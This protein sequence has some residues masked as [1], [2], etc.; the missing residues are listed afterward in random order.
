MFPRVRVVRVLLTIV[1]ILISGPLFGQTVTRIVPPLN[2][3]RDFKYRS[4]FECQPCHPRQFR[5][6]RQ[7][8]K[9]GYRNFSPT[10][11]TL[12]MAGNTNQGVQ[13]LLEAGAIRTNLRPPATGSSL[14]NFV[15]GG[16]DQKA[17]DE[18][19]G[20]LCLG[21]HNGQT[22][23]LGENSADAAPPREVPPWDGRFVANHT[24]GAPEGSRYIDGV[25][26]RPLRDYH[27]VDANGNQ[28]LPDKFG[29][30][31]PAGAQTSLGGFGVSCDYCHNV[32][33]PDLARSFQGDGFGNVGLQLLYSDF[34]A[35]PFKNAFPPFGRFHMS[36]NLEERINYIRSPMLCNACHDVRL[37]FGN[38]VAQ[39]DTSHP[40]TVPHYRLE[41]LSTEWTIGPY[42]NAAQNPFNQSVR[43]QDCHM[44]LYPYAGDSSYSVT[45]PVTGEQIQ[46]TSPTPAIFPINF[47]AEGVR[48]IQNGDYGTDGNV[49]LPRRQVVTHYFTG[50]D[51]PLLYDSELKAFLGDDYP[52]TD[53][54]GKD[55]YGIPQSIRTRREDLAKAA[56]R[57]DLDRS[58]PNATL[59]QEFT[60][61]VR[62]VALTGHRLPAGFSQ[63]RG[64]WI[65][66]TV[67][68]TEKNTGK[69]FVLYQSGYLVD[70]PHPE[71]NETTRD[72]N[73][74]DEDQEHLEAIVNPFNH[75]NEVFH[76][77]PD[78][79][80]HARIFEG[81]KE[82]LVF[83][84]NELIR[85]YGPARLPV[86]K[87]FLPIHNYDELLDVCCQPGVSPENCQDR[88][89]C[90]STGIPATN[91]NDPRTGE[92]LF[93]P[94]EEETF[95]AGS[96][97]FV[98]NWRSLPPLYPRTYG[99]EIH[100]PSEAELADLG[101]ELAG[102]LK[103]KAQVHFRHFPPLFLRFL[104]RV[105]GT[106]IERNMQNLPPFARFVGLRG[107]TN[108]NLNLWSEQR[109][110]DLLRI[111]RG[112]ATA[113][114]SVPLDQAAPASRPATKSATSWTSRK[115]GGK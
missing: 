4:P 31:P 104:S 39:D 89:R 85:I 80:S 27:F 97:N 83:L 68:A 63:E 13:T 62:A 20:G 34:K 84:R 16:G 42:N 36:T 1:A 76:L 91:R 114:I 51:V 6:N 110:D 98:D 58:D 46:I 10:F 21:C 87:A 15:T 90:V 35:G 81:V 112:I 75:D 5:E 52:S 73:F 78:D 48:G 72:G 82:G 44:S 111:M 59:G 53:E 61:R 40:S 99:Y 54:P 71:T 64:V 70:K 25:N 57:I 7:S 88:A 92:R 32:V 60:A 37:P 41:N 107:P 24:P 47:A 30:M 18:V 33:G 22:I 86:E 49:P 96:T 100:L 108:R 3:G 11:N 14:D 69:D 115:R 17:A 95:S 103:V 29:G 66:L 79:G 55:E 102:P 12:E 109:I 26:I 8:V 19:L 101:I 94:L 9:S 74:H 50:I 38:I 28:V 106:Y 93:H 77:G 2:T 65:Q 113:E 105:S 43:C 23:G 67:S 45:D 56:V